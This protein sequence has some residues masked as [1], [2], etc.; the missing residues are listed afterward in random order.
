MFSGAH[1]SVMDSRK[2]KS[3]RVFNTSVHP[4]EDTSAQRI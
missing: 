4:G 3:G 2:E 1:N